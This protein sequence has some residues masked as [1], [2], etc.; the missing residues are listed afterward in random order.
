MLSIHCVPKLLPT[1]HVRCHA[2]KWHTNPFFLQKHPLHPYFHRLYSETTRQ[3]LAPSR[4]FAF[5]S[6]RPHRSLISSRK[7][8]VMDVY[9]ATHLR[10]HTWSVPFTDQP[11]PSQ[12]RIQQGCRG[13]RVKLAQRLGRRPSA[14]GGGDGVNL[15]QAGVNKER[16]KKA[17]DA[18]SKIDEFNMAM[19][20]LFFVLSRLEI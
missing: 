18:E 10:P 19:L 13:G 1:R 6:P 8:F 7:K 20:S 12:S 16:L 11:V 2:G 4:V 14:G 5:C 15:A 9:S 17:M 3:H